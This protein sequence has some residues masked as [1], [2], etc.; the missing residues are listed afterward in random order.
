MLQACLEQL[1]AWLSGFS[2]ERV[3]FCV[4]V[5]TAVS[6]STS[7]NFIVVQVLHAMLFQACATND[8]PEEAFT[9][10]QVPLSAACPW[11]MPPLLQPLVV[12]GPFGSGK[13]AV[14]QRMVGLLLDVLAV[15]KVVTSKPHAPGQEEGGWHTCCV[16]SNSPFVLP[17]FVWFAELRSG[18]LR[19]SKL[20]LPEHMP[21]HV[22]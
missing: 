17:G 9:Q 3:F 20:S 15:P 22:C 13:R 2:A 16:S 7:L 11:A 10:L 14:L 8:D 19:G 5:L 18:M 4:N 21:T 12:A 6:A 1:S